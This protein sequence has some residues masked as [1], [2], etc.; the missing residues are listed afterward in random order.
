MTDYTRGTGSS[1]TMMIRD[2]WS[3]GSTNYNV[4]FWINSNNSSTFSDHIPWSYVDNGVP[5]SSFSYNY[6]AG[7]GWRRVGVYNHWSSGQVDFKLGA[8]GTSGFGGP[9][10]LSV[11]LNRATVPPAPSAVRY[12]NLTSTSVT[13]AFDGQGDGGS[14]IYT[15]QLGYGLSWFAPEIIIN[16][17]GTSNL[18]GLTPGTTYY[19]WARG[20]NAQGNGPWSPIS[21]V[22]TLRVPFTMDPPVASNL[23]QISALLAFTAPAD[24][25]APITSYQVGYS[26]N[27]S[28]L[29]PTTSILATS[30]QLMT[31]LQPATTYYFFARAQNSVGWSQWSAH[32]VVKTIAGARVN[33]AGVWKDAVP[34]VRD[35]GT[36]KLARPWVRDIGVWKESQ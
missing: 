35:S 30:P 14:V 36:W 6:P 27:P 1:G 16:S 29:A 33:V 28:D 10:T 18:T 25:G 23:T 4:E 5:S 26:T 12:S 21:S 13:A 19:M 3:P 20:V 8:T 22:T 31:G 34:Y 9:T 11:Y 24:G 2:Q 17:T 32:S 15:W 7:A